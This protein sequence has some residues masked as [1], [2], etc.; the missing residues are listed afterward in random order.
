M[1]NW[2]HNK[3]KFKSRGE[4]IINKVVCINNDKEEL[5]EEDVKFD[6]ERIIPMP[7]ELHITSGSIEDYAVQYALIR[8][9]NREELVD[10]LKKLEDTK[11]SFDGN[12]LRKFYRIK[13]YTLEELEEENKKF[14]KFIENKEYEDD[15][16]NDVDYVGLGIHNLEDFGKLYINNVIKYGADTW[17]DWHCKKLGL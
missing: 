5:G 4:E 10:T 8:M 12:Y 15:D 3:V 13:K 1:P 6:F 2:V 7:K 17:Y 9:N 11:V 14:I 16:F